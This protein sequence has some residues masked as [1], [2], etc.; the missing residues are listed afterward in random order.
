MFRKA[1][2]R[3][4]QIHQSKGLKNDIESKGQGLEIQG[5]KKQPIKRNQEQSREMACHT[6]S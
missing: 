4:G 1:E 2:R 6:H 3:F 5:D